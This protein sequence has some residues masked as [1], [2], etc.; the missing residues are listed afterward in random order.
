M[1]RELILFVCLFGF[2]AVGIGVNFPDLRFKHY[3]VESGM[4]ANTIFAITQDNKGFIWLATSN[5]L[6]RYDGRMFKVFSPS[7]DKLQKRTNNSVNCI[8]QAADECLWTGTDFGVAI[9]NPIDESFSY[10]SK[11]TKE[12][13]KIQSIVYSIIKDRDDNV[14]IGTFSQGVFLYNQKKDELVQFLHNPNQKFSLSSNNIGRLFEDSRGVIWVLTFDNGICSYDKLKHRFRFSVPPPKQESDRY[15]VMFEDSKG[16]LWLGC[17]TSGVAKFDFRSGKITPMFG[18]GES[19]LH[20]RGINEYAPGIMIFASD[21]GLSFFNTNTQTGKTVKLDSNNPQGLNDNYAHSIFIDKEGGL[22]VGTYF[23]GVN[24]SSPSYNNFML[25][26]NMFGESRFP[27]RVVSVMCEDNKGNL[28]IGTDDSGLVYYDVK[29]TSFKHFMPQKNKNSLSYHNIHA[30]LSDNN[31]LWIGTYS[32]GL[33]C[34]DIPTGKFKHYNLST[35]PHSSIYALYKD[36]SGAIWIGT[37]VGLA[38]YNKEKDCFELVKET[39]KTDVSCVIEDEKGYMWVST[40]TNGIFKLNKSTLKWYH[41][42]YSNKNKNSLSSDAV[43]TLSVDENQNLWVGTSGGG[44]CRYVYEKDEFQKYEQKEFPINCSIYKIISDN[45]YLWISTNM[46]LIRYQ[47][48]K[49]I[50]K[51]YNQ[52]DGLQSTLFC[53]NSGLKTSDGTIYFGGINGFNSF[54]PKLLLQNTVLPNVVLTDFKL[55]N[56]SVSCQDENSS[57]SKSI[58]YDKDIFISH[59]KSM[60]EFEFAA[61][62]YMASE[63]NKYKYMLEGFD[64]TWI[65]ADETAKATYTNL[66]AGKYVFRV[67]A[68]NNDELWNETGAVIQL[69]VLPPFWRSSL[70]IL[71]YLLLVVAAGVYF[72]RRF[73]EKHEFKYQESL[74]KINQEKEQ[75][76]LDAKMDFFTQ[77]IHEIRTPLTLIMGHLDFV[78]KSNKRIKE[79]KEDLF[80]VQR[81]SNRLYDLVNQLMDFRKIEVGSMTLQFENIDVNQLIAQIYECYKF[82][83]QSKQINIDLSLLP[84][85]LV[86]SSD[87]EALTKILNNLLS[88][89]LKFTKDSISIVVQVDDNHNLLLISVSDNGKGIPPEERENI[90]KPFYQIQGTKSADNIGTGIGL[91]LTDSLVT[92]L[93]GKIILTDSLSGGANFTLALPVVLASSAVDDVGELKSISD[94]VSHIYTDDA[95]VGGEHVTIND[96]LSTILIVDDNDDILKLLMK[97]LDPYY[98]IFSAKDATEGLKITKEHTLSLIISDIMMP[99]MDG[100]EFCSILKSN[101]ETCH[102]PV[103]LL[104][105]KTNIEAKIEGLETGA[106]AYIEKPFSLDYLIAQVNSLLRNREILLNRFANSPAVQS[107]TLAVSKLDVAFLKRVDEYIIKNMSETEF[108]IGALASE[109]GMSRSLYFSKFRALTGQ[110]PNNYIRLA[111]LKEAIKLLQDGETRINEI[112]FIVGFNSPSYFA[113]CFYQQFGTLPS[114]YINSVQNNDF[115]LEP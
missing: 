82:T 86:I 2:I 62:S 68:S 27:G 35:L 95:D 18:Q 73:K 34:L 111:R 75:E 64:R 26:N 13:T 30:L 100:F 76:L 74:I 97:C 21:D 52:S 69:T 41:Y 94:E 42:T 1:K 29:S 107:F 16:E 109:V 88:N 9:F 7:N 110:T 5:G 101:I 65:I 113:K 37:P 114:D 45:G 28:W 79:V 92:M 78:L 4:S 32:R 98:Q 40:L 8:M 112:C 83:A 33:D 67:K 93:E 63:K 106:D 115:S 60:I 77:I 102:L 31:K 38:K 44:L 55:F 48:E 66:P 59:D 80:V 47:P 89:A 57:L 43:Y 54:N 10:F 11:T 36:K 53:P 17:Y 24:Y 87:N 20:V 58:L 108:S 3:T 51:I 15:D 103:I 61:L 46:G 85:P 25:F 72:H 70:M 104:T 56:K 84:E 71:F 14:W 49:S 99:D 39:S 90:Y 23:G 81:N 22:W 19:I 91:M 12:G 105:A 50:L 96:K 6:N